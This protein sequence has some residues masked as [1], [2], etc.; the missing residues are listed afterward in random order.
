MARKQEINLLPTKGE[1]SRNSRIALAFVIASLGLVIL[2]TLGI[3]I[4]NRIMAA[5][6][7]LYTQL[8]Q[9]VDQYSQGQIELNAIIQETT[10]LNGQLNALK[11]FRDEPIAL[12]NILTLLEDSSP[13]NI[14]LTTLQNAYDKLTITGRADNDDEIMT[15][16]ANLRRSG[17]FSDVFISQI[18]DY[19][20][21]PASPAE[22]EQRYRAFSITLLYPT[23]T[24]TQTTQEETT[25]E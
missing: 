5:R 23:D 25:N 2:I 18:T 7:A 15:L 22:V 20:I 6:A 9:E 10:V 13:V 14:R 24:T 3:L 12:D 17:V 11:A 16:A 21:K 8:Q 19:I 4:P 1:A